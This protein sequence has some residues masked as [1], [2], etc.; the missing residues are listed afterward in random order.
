M[1]TLVKFAESE[2][3]SSQN[4]PSLPRDRRPVPTFSEFSPELANFAETWLKSRQ[5]WAIS[6]N[7]LNLNRSRIV[8][9]R[10]E[11][12]T[13][14]LELTNFAENWQIPRQNWRSPK[15][16]RNHARIGRI[17]RTLTEFAPGLAKLAHTNRFRVRC[18]SAYANSTPRPGGR[19][20]GVACAPGPSLCGS[21]GRLRGPPLHGPH[22]RLR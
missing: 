11:L 13:I 14:S 9:L 18:Q 5:N 10:H 22:G 1:P 16:G 21:A 3:N 15:L 17:R 19:E 4:W 6:P 20:A 2:P 7:N 12:S 8:Q